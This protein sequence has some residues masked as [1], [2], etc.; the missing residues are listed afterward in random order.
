MHTK[1]L[2]FASP[3]H[4]YAFQ[5]FL[6]QKGIDSTII[7]YKPVYYNDFNMR[8]PYETYK[9]QYENLKS[10]GKKDAETKKKIRIAKKRRDAYQRLYAER[11]IRYDKF[12]RFIEKNYQK[13]DACYDSDQLEILDPGFDCYICV[14]DVIWKNEPGEGFDR[15]YFLASKAMENKWKISYAASRGVHYAQTA[16]EIEKFFYYIEDIDWISVREDSLKGY[17]EE[18]SGKKQSWSLIRFYYWTKAFTRKWRSSRRKSVTY[19]FIM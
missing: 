5:Q 18:N 7:D 4:T 6:K 19:C 11:E 8:H 1:N 13:T 12:Q 9:I 15:G 14:T 10:S 2:N 3:L 16:N 17:I